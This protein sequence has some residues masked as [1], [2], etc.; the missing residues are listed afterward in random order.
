MEKIA[1]LAMPQSFWKKTLGVH[2]MIFYPN[3]CFQHWHLP[4]QKKESLFLYHFL[5]LICNLIPK[6]LGINLGF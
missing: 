3:F 2:G 4:K 5:K 6:S 1:N